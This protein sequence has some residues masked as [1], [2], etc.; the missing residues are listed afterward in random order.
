[1]KLL[2]SELH[3]IWGQ[4]IF[5]LCLA[6]LTAANLFLLYTGT[7]PGEHRADAAA[8]RAVAKDLQ[9][10]STQEQQALIGEK[11]ELVYGVLQIEQ[12]L[13]YSADGGYA[14]VNLREEY[15]E[16][17]DQYEEI[18]RSGEYDLYTGDLRTDYY[19]LSQIKAELDTVA[20]YPE[21]LE[22]VQTK[23]NQLSGI[24]IFQS[25]ASSYNQRNIDKTRKVYAGMQNVKIEYAPQKGLFTA[26]DY[27]FTDLILLAAMLLMASLLVRQ[28]RDSGMMN[29]IR[30]TPGGRLK[31][32]AAKLTALALTLLI[33]LFLMYGVNLLY[34]SLTFGLGSMSRTIQS[35]PALMRC[36][37]QITV[38]QYLVRFLLAKWAGAFVM[39]LW[40]MLAMLWARRTVLGWLG[41]LALPAVQWIIRTVIPAV[42]HW[43][44]IKYA[45]LA[46]LLRTNEL[47]GNYR[48][49]YWFDYPLSLP[50]VEWGAAVGYGLIFAGGFCWLFCRGQLRSAPV[51]AGFVRRT[52]R[53]R[54]TTVFG[55]ECR[56]LFLVCGAAAV[57]M[58]FAGYQTW[59]AI[60]TENYIDAE[61]IYYA[62]YMKQL[63]GP[64]TRQ[65]VR[66]LR[67][68]EQEFEPIYELQRQ[69]S[70]GQIDAQSYEIR[71]GAYYGLEQ[72]MNV[73]SGIV[74]NQ[75]GYIQEHPGAQLIYECGWEKLFG[76]SGNTDLQDALWAG[77][78]SSICFAGLFAF[79]K[80][81]GMQRVVMAAPLGRRRT[82]RSKLLAGSLAAVMI[83]MLTWVPHMFVALRDY[84]LPGLFAPAVSIWNYS[85]VPAW[86]PLI[87]IVMWAVIG[88][89]A[90][91]FAMMMYLFWLSDRLGNALAAMFVGS[92]TLCLA[93]MLALSGF[94]ALTWAGV[95]PLFHLAEMAQRPLD[96]LAG[97]LCLML[98]L[99]MCWLLKEDLY[100][101]WRC[102]RS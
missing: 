2:R 44:V 86:I 91:C 69:Y 36:T 80:K 32:A 29:V 99:A 93:P 74:H 70:S 14:G 41:A 33:V 72:K 67:R 52:T 34:C 61:G 102:G 17:F 83:G 10:L 25:E 71:R 15:A 66:D 23:A 73:F 60:K 35:V 22:E 7:K 92:I 31:T 8:Y 38:R 28:E 48:N 4:R 59:H 1:M 79:E 88:R 20:A 100:R 57:L 19:L 37:M 18:Y 40:V 63:E 62:Y 46:S 53:T 75:L 89:L 96:S 87:V 78:L 95:Y 65:T 55:Q 58:A 21:F 81:G 76:F 85:R 101:R 24:S 13:A 5:A 11:Q 39:G 16:L 84:G 49:L 56:K 27:Q 9:G 64:Y 6:V 77:L 45:N 82:L 51:F 97:A 90:A 42:S 3:K 12:L 94:T 68:M 54:A 47:L 26:L 98:A 50:L 30:S 43:N